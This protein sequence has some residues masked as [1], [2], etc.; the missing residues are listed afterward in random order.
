MSETDEVEVEVEVILLPDEDGEEKEYAMLTLVTLDEGV[1]AVLAPA[2][3]LNDLTTPNLDLYAFRW[4]ELGEDV[5]LDAV[6]DD[7]LLDR[8]FALA[9]EML[10]GDEE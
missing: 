5:E 6:E 7:A 4:T 8:I 1:F 3:Q 9:E 10:F 2:E